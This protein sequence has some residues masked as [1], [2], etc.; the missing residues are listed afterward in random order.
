M[1]WTWRLTS[2]QEALEK[3]WDVTSKIRLL[4]RVLPPKDY[5]LTPSTAEYDCIWKQGLCTCSQVKMMSVKWALV[6]C[7]WSPYK[8]GKYGHRDWHTHRENAKGKAKRRM[9]YPWAEGYQKSPA[10]HQKLGGQAWNRVSPIALRRHHPCQHLVL[11]LPA[12][13]TVRQSISVVSPK[14]VVFVLAAQAV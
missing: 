9:M 5:I 3:W 1:G 12:S 2:N 8:K 11:G 10:N 4:N 13:R 7:D 14:S 6:Q